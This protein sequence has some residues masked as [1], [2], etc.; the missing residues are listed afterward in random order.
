MG[1]GPGGFPSVERIAAFYQFSA[2]ILLDYFI[3][4]PQALAYL[5]SA[6][7]WRIP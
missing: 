2:G 3:V 5:S 1:S 4:W 7:L 6:I